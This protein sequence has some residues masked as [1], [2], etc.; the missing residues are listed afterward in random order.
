MFNYP[1]HKIDEI[2]F[3]L[4]DGVYIWAFHVDKIPPHVG[5]SF[6]GKYFSLKA[7]EVDME[8]EVE[9]IHKVTIRKKIPTYIIPLNNVKDVK[10]FKEEFQKFGNQIQEGESCMT[11]ILSF[12]EYSSSLLL[13]ELIAL[14]IRDKKVEKIFGI[15]LPEHFSGLSVYNEQDVQNHI[16]K[17][18]NAKG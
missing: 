2:P 10:S 1:L 18:R 15:N 13:E 17:L 4:Q 16:Q 12:L 14:L 9:I 5:I 6:Y 3:D 11:P 8:L 7:F